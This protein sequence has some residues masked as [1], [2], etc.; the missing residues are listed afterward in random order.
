LD[1]VDLLFETGEFLELLFVVLE[2]W[3]SRCE[4]LQLF[5]DVLVPKPLNGVKIELL[6]LYSSKEL[7]NEW[8]SF[9]VP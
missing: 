3:L 8:T 9:L 6:T 1:D 7:M 5:V 4:L 2:L